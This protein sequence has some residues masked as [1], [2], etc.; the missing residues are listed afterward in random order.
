MR[1]EGRSLGLERVAAAADH[2]VGVGV[3][4]AGRAETHDLVSHLHDQPGEFQAQALLVEPG[5]L[6]PLDVE[7]LEWGVV[8]GLAQVARDPS[9][10]TADGAVEAV[11]GDQET[12]RFAEVR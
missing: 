2:A 9:E 6:A 7:I 12:K 10:V 5:S 8:A 1:L 3:Q 4:L 11:S